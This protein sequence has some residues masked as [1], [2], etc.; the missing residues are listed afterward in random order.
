[1]KESDLNKIEILEG[2]IRAIE[3]ALQIPAPKKRVTKTVEH[4]TNIYE[5]EGDSV[6]PTQEAAIS[7]HRR[8]PIP[9]TL[10]ATVRMVGS[11]ETEEPE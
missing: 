9:K 3:D 2:R 11:Y 4:W 5:G 7:Y 1:M 8:C 6:H 10:I